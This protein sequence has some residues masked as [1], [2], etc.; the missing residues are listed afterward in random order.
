MPASS[1]RSWITPSLSVMSSMSLSPSLW[2]ATQPSSTA[3]LVSPF[4]FV[5]LY[6]RRLDTSPI[7][8]RSP[9]VRTELS[10]ML[11]IWYFIEELPAFRT[12]TFILFV[13]FGSLCLDSGYH[14]G[15]ENIRHGAASAE[16]VHR[17]VKTLKDRPYRHGICR[18]LNGFICSVTRIQVR[19][20]EDSGVSCNGMSCNLAAGK[21]D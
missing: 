18:T 17:F 5:H 9:L 2:S 13:L 8:S 15:I 20:Y 3:S 4:P 6:L 1:L 16:V 19:E 21:F 11:K 14:D 12:I 10:F 7:C